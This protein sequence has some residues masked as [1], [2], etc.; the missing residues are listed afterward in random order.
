MRVLFDRVRAALP[1]EIDARL[2]YFQEGDEERNVPTSEYGV[3]GLD[4]LNQMIRFYRYGAGQQFPV[5][6]DNLTTKLRGE[7]TSWLSVLFYLS[8][9]FQG[10]NTAFFR[11]DFSP[12]HEVEP[13]EGDAVVFFHQ[14]RKSPYHAGL[15]VEEGSYKYV[16]RSD[17]MYTASITAERGPTR[18]VSPPYDD[19]DSD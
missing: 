5:H 11:N 9:G 10:G 12:A 1:P 14:G 6:R 2:E 7:H 4:S 3:W 18:M 16:L 19:S 15:P 8:G 17:A 13:M